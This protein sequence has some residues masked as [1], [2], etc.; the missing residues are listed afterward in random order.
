MSDTQASPV[1]HYWSLSLE[2]QFYLVWPLLGARPRRTHPPP[3]G[4]DGTTP[5][6]DGARRGARRSLMLSLL[7]TSSAG[8]WAYFGPDPRVGLATGAA[9]A[10]AAHRFSQ[11]TPCRVAA[12]L[13]R[14]RHGAVRRSFYSRA[15]PYPG[16][17]MPVPVLGTAL[18]LV[19][20][21]AP[22]VSGSAAPLSHPPPFTSDASPY[23][24]YLW[25]WPLAR[26]RRRVALV[27]S[28]TTTP[29]RPTMA[30]LT[31]SSSASSVPSASPPSPTASSRTRYAG[32]TLLAS[33][34]QTFVVGCRPHRHLGARR[35]PRGRRRGPTTRRAPG[36][37]RRRPTSARRRAGRRQPPSPSAPRRRAVTPAM[38]P[39]QARAD[40]RPTTDCFAGFV[41]PPPRPGASSATRRFED[42]RARRRLARRAV[43]PRARRRR[44]GAAGRSGSGP[45]ARCPMT[46][47]DVWLPS[48]PL[49]STTPAR[50][51]AAERRR[52]P[53]RPAAARPRRRRPQQGL[54]AGPRARRRRRDRRRADVPPSGRRVRRSCS[55]TSAA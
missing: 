53:R 23:G 27:R 49:R 40:D 37:R 50:P 51:G 26:R 22:A 39:A 29:S 45:R 19:S 31:L 12:R 7:L 9:L 32:R 44:Q 47:V 34:R 25:H 28:P 36:R 38:T 16:I 11:L 52:P 46:E 33:K 10:L 21:R 8:P 24:W 55:P 17:A 54:P 41:R 48:Y 35:R 2:E 4:R 13:G 15:T 1:L 14:P 3:L 43:A 30:P 20:A 18:V 42:R 6:R 5:P